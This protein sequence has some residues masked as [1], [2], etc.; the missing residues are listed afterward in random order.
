MKRLIYLLQVLIIFSLNGVCQSRVALETSLGIIIIELDEQNAPVTSANF[1]RYV[2]E[3]R[4]IGAHFYRVVTMQNQPQNDIKIEV[5][6]GGLGD[7]DSLRLPTIQHEPTNKTGILHKNGTFSMARTNPGTENSE[8]FI[9]IND[10]P[11]LDHGGMRNPDGMGF[12]AFGKVVEGM[13]VVLE[14]QKLP[15]KNESG[16][17]LKNSF[18]IYSIKRVSK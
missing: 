14:I 12:S 2:D 18:P 16:Q 11:E 4:W 10:Q 15:Q 5:I 13:N 3:N 1:L 6:Q 8:F 7:L 9:C 17:Y